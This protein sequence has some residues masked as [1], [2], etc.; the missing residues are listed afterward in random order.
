MHGVARKPVGDP[1]VF[2][3]PVVNPINSIV[4]GANP[5]RAIPIDMDC[6]GIDFASIEAR[7]DIRKP[8]S[9][10]RNNAHPSRGPIASDSRPNR[11][12]RSDCDIDYAF[13]RIATVG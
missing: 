4:L 10:R 11:T 3:Y 13:S 2:R 5:Q 6:Q 7:N 8:T 12:R 9:R 1:V